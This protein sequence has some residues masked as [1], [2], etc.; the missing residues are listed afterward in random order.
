MVFVIGH[1]GASSSAP[2]NTIPSFREAIELRV[3]FIEFDVH[4]S[5]D[6]VLVV[7]H[8]STLDRTTDM[9][10]PV[11]QF[12]LQQ[13][14]KMDAGSWFS[15]RFRGV[16]IPT[17][18]EVLDL[19]K[20]KVSVA[21]EIKASAIEKDLTNAIIGKDMIYSS[22]ILI[23]RN[24]EAASRIKSLEPRIPIQADII[25][26]SELMARKGR[27]ANERGNLGPKE[28]EGLLN[29]SL[30]PLSRNP[31]N[32]ASI[33][34]TDL[35]WEGIVDVCHRRGVL[36]NAWP[37]NDREGMI[38][39]LDSGIDFMT[40]DNPQLATSAYTKTGHEQGK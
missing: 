13:L 7:I 21:P 26:V 10:G 9:R 14:K 20:G 36:A 3:D 28:R 5:K 15:P 29:E 4:R 30:D 18:E 35:A 19:A 27:S 8:D 24:Y 40:T 2:E 37:V 12:T 17:V 32:I 11:S 6:G 16:Q 33:H 22:M 39:C 23:G 1:R 34:K 25:P 38:K 31:I